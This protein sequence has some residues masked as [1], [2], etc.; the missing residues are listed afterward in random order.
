MA[1]SE[2]M[3]TM[4]ASW[5][6]SRAK[7]GVV[8]LRVEI[9]LRLAKKQSWRWACSRLI[10]SVREYMPSNKIQPKTPCRKR[11]HSCAKA[12]YAC[13]RHFELSEYFKRNDF[14]RL[15]RSRSVCRMDF[16]VVGS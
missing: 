14:N 3:P 2:D 6:H 10:I 9:L 7:I 15:P 5:S 4:A 8:R 16:M 11:Q 12:K 13:G 1:E